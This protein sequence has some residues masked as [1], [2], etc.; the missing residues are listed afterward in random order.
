MNAAGET[1]F[2]K[3]KTMFFA[4]ILTI[5]CGAGG[6][7]GEGWKG[8]ANILIAGKHLDHDDW[9]ETDSQGEIGLATNWQGPRWPI[10][11]AADLLASSRDTS[12]SRDGFTEQK[13]ST[14]ELDLGARKIWR[15]DP[16]LRPYAGGGLDLASAEIERTGPGGRISDRDSGVGIW[17]DGG[18]MWTLSEVFNLGFDVR[19]SGAQVRL[20]GRDVAAGGLHLGLLAG[21]HWG[22]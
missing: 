7:R 12:I 16:S 1:G 20:F 3:N 13:G 10:A 11:L 8:D 21:Y 19:L 9:G 14:S 5:L 22:G 17:L 18:F 4:A 15:P 6:A 2:M